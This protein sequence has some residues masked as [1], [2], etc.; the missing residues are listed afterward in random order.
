VRLF[1]FLFVAV[2]A[3]SA[4]IHGQ[5]VPAAVFTDPPADAAHPAGM[6]VIHFPSHGVLINGLV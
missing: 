1:A 2:S 4:A 6:T 3:T 5:S